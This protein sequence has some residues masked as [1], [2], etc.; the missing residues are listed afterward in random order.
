MPNFPVKSLIWSFKYRYIKNS[1]I[2]ISKT[3]QISKTL[4]IRTILSRLP[5]PLKGGKKKV[6]LAYVCVVCCTSHLSPLSTLTLKSHPSTQEFA[7]LYHIY[8]T[9]IM[10]SKERP[11][12]NDTLRDQIIHQ[13]ISKNFFFFLFMQYFYYPIQFT[14]T[15]LWRAYT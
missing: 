10:A 6:G 13:W 11:L 14:S 3:L 8:L 1:N 7:L 4:K 5:F 2:R 15:V 9:L 12:C